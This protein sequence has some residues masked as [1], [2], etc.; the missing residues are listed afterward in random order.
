[1]K[2]A[3]VGP[4]SVPYVFGGM[5]RF[6]NGLI[7]SLIE[8]GHNA[9]LILI[10]VDEN[11]FEGILKGYHDFYY[12][13]L[14]Q[15][16]LVI[17]CK[18]PSFMIQHKCH[19][20][21]L[22][23]RMRV[24]YDLY[25]YRDYQHELNKK[26]IQKLDNWA[27]SPERIKKQFAIGETVANRLKKWGGLSSQVVYHPT[28]LNSFKTGKYEYFLAVSRLHH[29]KRVDL[30]IEAFKLFP[31]DYAIELH[32]VG[33]GPE[34]QQLKK[35]A[36]TD[37]RIKFI[38]R[39]SDDRLVN[40]Y[41]DALAVLFT[42]VNEDLGMVTIEAFMSKKAVV[43][44][45]DSG[46]PAVI[47]KHLEN[48]M[49]AQPN[50]DSIF[51]TMQYLLDH[52]DQASL[53][54]EAGYQIAQK[55]TWR[56]VVRTLLD[57]VEKEIQAKT[58]KSAKVVIT[59]NQI[60]DPP[61][62][63]GRIR[64]YN[65]FR[66]LPDKF[67]CT[68]VGTYDWLGPSYREQQLAP[69]LREV[70]TPLTVPHFAFDRIFHRLT[71]RKVTIDVTIPWLLRFSP[72][73]QRVLKENLLNASVVVVSHPWVY[74]YVKRAIKNLG[75]K[76][77]LV[78]DSHNCE[79]VVKKQILGDS[80]I[81]RMLVRN[82]FS[83]EKQLCQEADIIFVCSSEDV[84]KFGDHYRVSK[85]KMVL[86]PNGVMV[87]E[88]LPSKQEEKVRCKQDLGL[89][90]NICGVFVG[91]NYDPNVD[92]VKFIVDILAPQL[93][94]VNFLIVG[95]V[96]EGFLQAMADSNELPNNVKIYG[97][98]DDEKRNL[99]YKAADFAVN[100]MFRGSGTNIKMFD[101]MSAKLPVVS[102]PTGA[103]GIDAEY[104]KDFIVCAPEQMLTN[105][106]SLLSQHEKMEQM[107]ENA[108]RLVEKLYDWKVI[109]QKAGEV[110]QGF[111]GEG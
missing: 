60:L 3:L 79:Y 16:D 32:V 59:D 24:F 34:E 78:Y 47:I 27:L 43:T 18:A 77:V 53:M 57:G 72:K 56:N 51:F 22:N 4:K 82:I 9:D 101:F 25:S 1:M 94:Y 71:G 87:D 64:I 5:D 10:P 62:G 98:V 92:A 83:V 29:L 76:P 111:L 33:E 86:I 48:G 104:G 106:Q 81:G 108:R 52:R 36:A 88:I 109:G 40:E 37:S 28:N 107:G 91:S 41:A 46:E 70:V 35:L 85:E 45:T 55:I 19:L 8:E 54:G 95:G 97:I 38:G 21:Y 13:N 100:P 102:T 26:L 30:I 96:G 20:N 6:Y 11:S 99:V 66:N 65:L 93:P 2:I 63:G 49:I 31:S 68:Y 39:V 61:V 90:P 69:T 17:S 44:C 103:R 42:P 12:L 84:G 67:D 23:H 110:L 15:Y 74:P 73:Y 58:E 89:P 105:I 75:N 7:Q 50:P 80:L 14:D